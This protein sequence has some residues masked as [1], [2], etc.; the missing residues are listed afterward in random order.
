[1]TFPF[2]FPAFLR[3]GLPAVALSFM[4]A[5]GGLGLGVAQA[6]PSACIEQAAPTLATGG[7]GGTGRQANGGIGGTGALASGGIGGT[8]RQA[9][10]G[11]GGTGIVGT[12]TG[13]A[14]VCVN[15]L[16]VHYDDATPV[17]RNGLPTELASLAVG[18]VV[19]ID[20]LGGE[21]RLVAQR[22]G[23]LNVLE[24]P[25]TQ[26]PEEGGLIRVMGQRVLVDDS[27]RLAGL[28]TLAD[29]RPGMSLR[30]AGFRGP[31]DRILAT[32]LEYAPDQADSSAIGVLTREGGD[33]R[34][35]GLP[36]RADAP[37][38]GMATEALLRGDWDGSRLLV[39]AAHARPSLPFAGRVEHMVVECLVLEGSDGGGPSRLRIS[40]FEVERS[41]ATQVDVGGLL[42]AGQRVIVSGRLVDAG[43]LVAERIQ[44]I[45]KPPLRG[46]APTAAMHPRGNGQP[47]DGRVRM[48]NIRPEFPPRI[49]RMERIPMQRPSML[50]GGIHTPRR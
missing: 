1:M 12:V 10:G 31:D 19:V 6:N 44:S 25:L 15:G 41:A 13:F 4:A 8:G 14:S 32:R 20:A 16:E 39:R 34:L 17:T 21:T 2:P 40:G 38:P 35:D 50:P 36:L 37:L 5:A 24:G 49:E 11:I 47:G 26:L 22:I 3:R 43:R 33:L 30:V 46:R 9:D 18:Q 27:T 29:L 23:L 42:A 48:E 45:G 28:S 7:I